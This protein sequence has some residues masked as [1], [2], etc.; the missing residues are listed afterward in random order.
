MNSNTIKILIVT[1][2]SVVAVLVFSSA[3]IVDETERVVITQFGRIVGE[4]VK[5]PGLKFKT[6][7]IQTANYFPKKSAGMGW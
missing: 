3:Y 5:E 7:F 6:P 4:S 1:I 2:V